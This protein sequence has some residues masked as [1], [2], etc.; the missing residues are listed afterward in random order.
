[1]AVTASAGVVAVLLGRG[2]LVSLA[3]T[4]GAALTVTV[5]ELA[6]GGAIAVLAAAAVIQPV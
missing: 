3:D 4:R 1:M 5:L 6:G 2:V